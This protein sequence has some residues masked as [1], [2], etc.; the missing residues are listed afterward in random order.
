MKDSISKQMDFAD[1]SLH[2]E[3]FLHFPPLQVNNTNPI[4][5]EWI[6]TYQHPSDD[7]LK[8]KHKIMTDNLTQSLM[9][10]KS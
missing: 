5:H 6:F 1:D 9:K 10:K 8:C 2:I 7:L 4:E 3:G